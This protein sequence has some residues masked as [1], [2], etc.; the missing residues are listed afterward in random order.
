MCWERVSPEERALL[1][2]IRFKGRE[3]RLPKSRAL[4]MTVGILL[5]LGGFLWV[6]PFFAL[7]MIPLGLVVLSIDLPA[8]RRFRRRSE[9]WVLRRWKAAIDRYKGPVQSDPE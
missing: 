8:V 5:V 7:W 6:L 4:R 9:V 2:K 1:S 3:V